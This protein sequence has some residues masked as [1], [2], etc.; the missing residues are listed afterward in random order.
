[1]IGGIFSKRKIDNKKRDTF[2]K[3]KVWAFQRGISPP[4]SLFRTLLLSENVDLPPLKFV[5]EKNRFLK[6]KQVTSAQ[7]RCV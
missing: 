2:L 5:L 4:Q 3:L 1:M 6:R 7:L